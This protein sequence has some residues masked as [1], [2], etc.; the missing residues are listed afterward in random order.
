M[1][2]VHVSG[3]GPSRYIWYIGTWE[4]VQRKL[5]SIT[6]IEQPVHT[7]IHCSNCS[8]VHD[9]VL[10]YVKSFHTIIIVS[11][12]ETTWDNKNANETTFIVSFS[13]FQNHAFSSVTIFTRVLNNFFLQNKNYN[14][15][16]QFF[17]SRRFPWCW[18]FLRY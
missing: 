16:W 7:Y 6:I 14:Y 1:N 13:F 2:H 5:C 9:L 18:C 15:I 8:A 11:L 10:T 12:S 17:F 3:S 4:G